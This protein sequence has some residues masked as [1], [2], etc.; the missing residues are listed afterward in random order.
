VLQSLCSYAVTSLPVVQ[1]A[2]VTVQFRGAPFMVAQTASW[3]R[4]MQER[5]FEGRAGPGL[6]ALHTRRVVTADRR[7]L[8]TRWPGLAQATKDCGVRAVHAEPLPVNH[9]PVG[10][11]ILFSTDFDV[12]DP[13]LE[14]L[15]PVRDLLSAALT[16]YCTAHPHEDHAIRLRRALHDRQL[17]RQAIGILIARHGI[18]EDR[19]GRMLFENARAGHV[20]PSTAAR[21]IIRQHVSAGHPPPGFAL[22]GGPG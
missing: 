9:Q 18:S 11:L 19:A 7:E 5:E 3:V 14:R 6:R 4:V 12:L 17:L 8:V 21:S 10:V 16:G 20:T 13:R 15:V 2:G 1:L 22:T